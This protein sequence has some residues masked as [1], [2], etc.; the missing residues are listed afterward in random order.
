MDD[1]VSKVLERRFATRTSREKTKYVIDLALETYLKQRGTVAEDS[2]A[3]DPEFK[4]AAIENIK[5]FIFA[6]HD[7]SSSAVCYC[8]Y[9]LSRHPDALALLR[10]ECDDIFGT[11]LTK[12]GDM[13]KS[14]PY[15]LNKM[16]YGLAVLREILRLY[17]PANAIRK[18]SRE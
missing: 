9:Q 8:F 12:T 13:I 2:T 16:E 5:I 7:T 6:G 15:L 10:K 3:L 11:D 18:G 14:D 4:K 17:P 1:Y